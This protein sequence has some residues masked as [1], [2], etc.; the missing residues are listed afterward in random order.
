MRL[1][2]P[3]DQALLED[4]IEEVK[5]PMP[6]ACKGLH[7]LL[8][9]PFRYAPYP[10]GSRF[11]RA[12]Q[13]EGAFYAAEAVQTALHELAF[14]R[15]LF[16]AESPGTVL[17]SL[18]K[19]FTA[20]SVAVSVARLIDLTAAPF[21]EDSAVWIHPTDYEGCQSLADAARA[22]EVEAVRYQS[23]RDPDAGCNVALL[24]PAGFASHQP[25]RI[26]TWAL[27]LR[28][29]GVQAR[30]EFPRLDLHMPLPLFS[31]DPRLAPLLP[32]PPASAR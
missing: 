22:A 2:E 26:E 31:A 18:P 12:G 28:S 6:A 32:A 23:V 17:P 19:E 20:F 8:A 10:H 9:T 30:R 1:A 5:P 4:L 24:T 16:F 7:F 11:R 27:F 15:L 21:A 29:D 3:D 25:K 14:Y 13:R